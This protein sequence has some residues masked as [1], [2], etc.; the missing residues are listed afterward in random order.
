M[1]TIKHILAVAA[2][3]LMPLTLL[4]Q[5]KKPTLM[6]VPAD[7][8]CSEHGYTRADDPT[9]AD[10][11]KAL[12]NDTELLNVISKIGELMAD[13][14]FPLK[15]MAQALRS[16]D[17][18]LQRVQADILMELSW[19][20]NK[21]GPKQSVTY[22]LR[23]LDAYTTKQV[24]AASGTGKPSIACE[25]PVLL[26][27]AVLEQMDGFQA[28]L[29][30]HF[31]DLL[32]NGREVTVGVFIDPKSQSV[33]QLDSDIDDEQLSDIIED[34]MQENT[35]SRRF[36]LSDV[37]DHSMLFEQVRIPLYDDNDMPMDTR[38]FVSKLHRHLNQR[39]LKSKVVT[40]GLGRADLIINIK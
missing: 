24:A 5:A 12:Q 14:G 22:T 23:G 6:V 25:V 16:G 21:I 29:Q 35:V 30:Q 4:A 36:S 31:D 13:R 28:Q 1:K 32:T 18:D 9:K 20:I 10:Y 26:Q 2:L 40:K 27:E 38:H 17:E 33:L 15:D 11:A 8:W 39:G 37:Q 19:K 7:A 34:W 3:S